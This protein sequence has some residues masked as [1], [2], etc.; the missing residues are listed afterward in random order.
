MCRP[1]DADET[2]T[3][4]TDEAEAAAVFAP[5]A[6]A[7]LRAWPESMFEECYVGLLARLQRQA[8]RRGHRVERSGAPCGRWRPGLGQHLVAARVA[9]LHAAV[10]A[11]D[12]GGRRRTAAGHRA[13]Q[14]SQPGAWAAGWAGPR[15]RCSRWAA[16]SG[17]TA[18][19]ACAA[20][21]RATAADE[22]SGFGQPRRRS[23]RPS[24]RC[25]SR[26][27]TGGWRRN[28]PP[29]R[30]ASGAARS[31][32]SAVPAMGHGGMPVVHGHGRRRGQEIER[33][34]L[35]TLLNSTAKRKSWQK[36][37]VWPLAPTKQY[38]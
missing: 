29:G 9:H 1:D 11:T 4:E 23:C 10:A 6:H 14:K 35:N 19:A 3:I 33:E 38:A 12:E 16:S 22:G 34:K 25:R 15:L 30:R 7:S 18:G 36:S 5:S 28:G 27:R 21:G 37:T 17:G 20:C 2:P 8:R 13:A 31:R 24:A 32:Q 26:R